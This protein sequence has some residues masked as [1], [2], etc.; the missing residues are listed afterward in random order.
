[1]IRKKWHFQLFTKTKSKPFTFVLVFDSQSCQNP[2]I[3]KGFKTQVCAFKEANEYIRV[4]RGDKAQTDPIIEAQIDTFQ[5]TWS[6]LPG[7][8]AVN[9]LLEKINLSKGPRITLSDES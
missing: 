6:E 8:H 2:K 1:M 5:C 9:R 3:N 4:L 7:Y